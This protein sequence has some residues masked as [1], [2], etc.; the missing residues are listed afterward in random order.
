M[1]KNSDGIK[2]CNSF[3]LNGKVYSVRSACAEFHLDYNEA[4]KALR[5]FRKDKAL[6]QIKAV[7]Y[8][9]SWHNAKAAKPCV[10]HGKV[11]V[12][13]SAACRAASQDIG[14]NIQ[15]GN[16]AYLLKKHSD[17]GKAL[18]E[19]VEAFRGK[20]TEIVETWDAM[21]ESETM[22]VKDAAA[23][24]PGNVVESFGLNTVP[25]MLLGVTMKQRGYDEET[26]MFMDLDDVCHKTYFDVTYIYQIPG[27]IADSRLQ[28]GATF[29]EAFLT[30]IGDF[31]ASELE[32]TAHKSRYGYHV[33][34]QI[35][36]EEVCHWAIEMDK[37]FPTLTKM[38]NFYG[39][40]V[41]YFRA[42]VDIG[43]S[44]G[45]AITAEAYNGII[46]TASPVYETNRKG[47]RVRIK[48]P[49][50]YCRSFKMAPRTLYKRVSRNWKDLGH[51]GNVD[52]MVADIV[53]K[54]RPRPS[55]ATL[56]S[57][58]YDPERKVYVDPEGNTYTSFERM[59]LRYYKR[60][61]TVLNAMKKGLTIE[62]A[63]IA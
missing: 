58:G 43:C 37:W 28:K 41:G 15:P 39:V 46:R 26:G 62:E 5:P 36:N 54:H 51:I 19:Y 34:A 57:R 40:S 20:H 6:F 59:C 13:R 24:E 23:D 10:Y 60:V 63:L 8:F 12:S 42:A 44:W 16:I 50:K 47:R 31:H 1:N 14:K 32:E 4:R 29:A 49:Y 18:E 38:C 35:V 2:R 56:I 55:L 22:R 7:E 25:G 9:G 53:S 33:Q 3:V 45:Q 30:K 27:G 21:M 11:Y 48:T 61:R 17:F 52:E